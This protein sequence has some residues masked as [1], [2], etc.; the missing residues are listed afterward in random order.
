MTEV[1]LNWDWQMRLADNTNF[2]F[3]V[4]LRMALKGLKNTINI[5]FNMFPVSSYIQRKATVTQ[6]ENDKEKFLNKVAEKKQGEKCNWRS[7]CSHELEKNDHK[8]SQPQH[9]VSQ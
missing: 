8:Q 3:P 6:K 5:T 7:Q 1:I 4:V 9:Q 2:I